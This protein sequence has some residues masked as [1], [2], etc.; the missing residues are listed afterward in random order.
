MKINDRKTSLELRF[1]EVYENN[2]WGDLESKSGAGS[3][4][5]S[6]SVAESIK[7]LQ[8]IIKEYNIKSINDIPCG[9]F[10][11]IGDII[12]NHNIDYLGFDIVKK[13][14]VDN[15]FKYKN[16]KFCQLDITQ[17][18]P[19]RADLIFCKDLLN[20]LSYDDIYM[21]ISNMKATKS[22]FFLSSNNFNYI[23]N[24]DL[25]LEH[26]GASRYLDL[27]LPPFNFPS[28]SWR[29]SYLG[30]WDLKDIPD[31]LT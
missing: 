15:T 18:V 19:P 26:S 6:P 3:R 9:D 23:D 1:T 2:V 8:L 14:V 7:A 29:S 13:I 5:D 20:H 24:V 31:F 28:P 4:L 17:Q 11:W 21:S 25:V 22:K 27:M 12:E 10:N 16:Y 30:L